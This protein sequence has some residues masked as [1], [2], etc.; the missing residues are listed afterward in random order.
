MERVLY[1]DK[2]VEIIERGNKFSRIQNIDN[3]TSARTVSTAYLKT[4][5]FSRNRDS[6]G[7]SIP[8]P[9][10]TLSPTN[11][12]RLCEIF[13]QDSNFS[14][15]LSVAPEQ[16]DAV[17]DEIENAADGLTIASHRKLAP[18]YDVVFSASAEVDTLLEGSGGHAGPYFD[19]AALRVFNGP[20]KAFYNVFLDAGFKPSLIGG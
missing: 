6:F 18:S 13:R 17:M 11:F 7:V 16:E 3:P 1:F 20:R 14:M 19:S 2:E 15:P 8:R 10:L 12:A 4:L 5:R 9:R